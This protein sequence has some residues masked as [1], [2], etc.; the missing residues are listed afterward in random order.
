MADGGWPRQMCLRL[1]L[2]GLCGSRFG[3][4][5]PGIWLSE[6][7]HFGNTLSPSQLATRSTQL[8]SVS[9]RAVE[10]AHRGLEKGCACVWVCHS[11]VS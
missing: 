11:G 3:G 2:L 1:S 7:Q 5:G 9:E 6:R 4:W 8:I 10:V